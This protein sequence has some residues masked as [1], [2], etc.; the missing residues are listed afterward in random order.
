[1]NKILYIRTSSIGQ[2]SERQ[3][4]NHKEYSKIIED[5]VSGAIPFFNRPGGATIL[6]MIEKKVP[7]ILYVHSIDRLGRDLLDILNTIRHFNEHQIPIHFITQGLVTID[8]KG[9]ENYITTMLIGLLGTIAQMER[10]QI[11][12]RQLQGIEVAKLKGVYKGRANG[13]KEDKLK[14]LSKYEKEVELYRKG[15]K[16]THINSI[17]GTS[18]NTLTKL[19]KC[20]Q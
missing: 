12:E 16:A 3:Q 1:M 10:A 9:K 17:T 4:V 18:L 8:N 20:L 11:K 2:N 19:K 7:F 14:F 15:Y 6:R 5:K 13:T